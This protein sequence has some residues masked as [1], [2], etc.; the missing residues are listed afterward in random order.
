M[1]SVECFRHHDFQMLFHIFEMCRQ[2]PTEFAVQVELHFLV[3]GYIDTLRIVYIDFGMSQMITPRGQGQYMT[4][5]SKACLLHDDQGKIAII[6]LRLRHQFVETADRIGESEQEQHDLSF[7]NIPVII[8][9]HI[10]ASDLGKHFN[11]LD[12]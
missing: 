6:E 7:K 9:P 5:S 1:Y 11:S 10:G 12:V 4:E 3:G 2:N 8:N